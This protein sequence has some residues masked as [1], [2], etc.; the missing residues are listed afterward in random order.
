MEAQQH[1]DVVIM[2][3]GYAGNVQARHLTRKIP[4]IK[5]AV[6][7]PRSDEKVASIH[8]IGESTVEIGAI[9]LS[10]ELGL[11][12]Y[13]IENHLPK[14][15]LAF[16]WPKD[17][18]QTDSIDDY[19]SIWPPRFPKVGTFQVHRGK[20][21]RDLR[22]MNKADGVSFFQGKVKDFQ[23]REDDE[24]H[25][26]EIRVSGEGRIKLSADHLIDAASRA[27]LTGKKTDNIIHD[28]EDLYGLHT[29]AVW[30]RVKGV[31]RELF[32]KDPDPLK[33]ATSHYYSTNHWFGHGHW[34]WMIPICDDSMSISIGAMFHHSE[35]DGSKLDRKEKFLDF[36]KSNHRAL[37]DIVDSGEI[38]DFVYWKKPSHLCK[39]MFSKDNWYAIGDAAYF[40]DAFYSLGTTTIAFAVESVTEIIRAKHAGECPDSI[41]DKRSAYNDFNVYYGQTVMHLYR[42]HHKHLGNASA[43][44]W[45]I[46][47]EYMWWFGVWVPAFIGKWHLDP[48]F[49]RATIRHCEK[50]FF[51]TMYD[52]FSRMIDEG[53]NAGFIDCYRADQL[54]FGYCPTDEHTEYMEDAIFEPQRLDIYT[55]LARTYF[56]TS[57]FVLKYQWKAFGLP[58]LLSPR[59]W[60]RSLRLLAKSG[61]MK[62]GS[63][64]HRFEN[65]GRPVSAAHAQQTQDFKDYVY[66]PNLQPWT[67]LA[68]P[69]QDETIDT[70]PRRVQEAAPSGIPSAPA[71]M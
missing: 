38:E 37:F 4:G 53:R 29:G 65:R 55:S 17:P 6:I 47:L 1:F 30:V 22:A 70:L 32:R 10:K 63:L 56:L 43:M 54:A 57:L 58:G 66:K 2:G 50:G 9:F 23:M 41:E 7:D 34:F 16:H 39:Q 49:A 35:V 60:R 61:Y 51:K 27:F 68:Q 14:C 3:G 33:T 15:G 59:T 26:V 19:H 21:E 52:D 48:E 36:V 5:V 46:Y 40:G 71:G 67:S 64:R 11:V 44:S 28:P 8:K 45:R 69:E 42:D 31:D 24:A 62:M 20:L 25:E 13:L 12:D 18:A